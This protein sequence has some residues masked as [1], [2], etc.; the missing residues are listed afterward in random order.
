MNL[1]AASQKRVRVAA[2]ALQAS[3][4]VRRAGPPEIAI[5]EAFGRDGSSRR[6]AP[7][8]LAESEEQPAGCFEVTL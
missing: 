7:I 3:E 8:V 1:A 2:L 4:Q 5:P 6:V